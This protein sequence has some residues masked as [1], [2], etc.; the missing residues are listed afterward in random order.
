MDPGCNCPG[1]FVRDTRYI[2]ESGRLLLANGEDPVCRV[3]SKGGG[4]VA[5][6]AGEVLVDENDVHWVGMRWCAYGK[7]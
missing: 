7:S 4:D 6:L 1:G 3:G 2:P 5:E